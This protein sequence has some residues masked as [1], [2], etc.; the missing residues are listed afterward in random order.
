MLQTFVDAYLEATN[1]EGD[2]EQLGKAIGYYIDILN[3]TKNK[4]N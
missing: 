1:N 2:V 4:L 3:Q